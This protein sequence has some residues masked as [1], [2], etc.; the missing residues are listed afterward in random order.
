MISD[1]S[2]T[3]WSMSV[4]MFNPVKND[5]EDVIVF[6]P[7]RIYNM[8]I[9]EFIRRTYNIAGTDD[10]ILALVYNFNS[11]DKFAIC[12]DESF[13]KI[14]QDFWMVSRERIED[15]QEYLRYE[16]G[17]DFSQEVVSSLIEY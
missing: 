12:E 13:L 16:F 7:V 3:C 11:Y 6:I 8:A 14:C 9:A 17:I 4:P 15:Y 2:R 1:E 10:S 5:N